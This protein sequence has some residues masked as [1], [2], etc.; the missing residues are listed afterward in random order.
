MYI[1][2]LNSKCIH[3]INLIT[4]VS[5]VFRKYHASRVAALYVDDTIFKYL[6]SNRFGS[7]VRNSIGARVEQ[8]PEGLHSVETFQVSG[9][10]L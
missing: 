2:C 7:S 10:L 1:R 5:T 3:L 9:F 6:R 4:I 8:L